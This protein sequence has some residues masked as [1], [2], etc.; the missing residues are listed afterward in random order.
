[1]TCML[2]NSS[3]LIPTIPLIT[4]VSVVR[5]NQNRATHSCSVQSDGIIRRKVERL[6]KGVDKRGMRMSIEKGE[7]SDPRSTLQNTLL[8]LFSGSSA[9]ALAEDRL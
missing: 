4:S 9:T 6:S 3:Y 5:L 8:Y 2:N 7:G 1:M